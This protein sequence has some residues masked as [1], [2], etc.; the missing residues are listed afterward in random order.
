MDKYNY[1]GITAT[2][3]R[4]LSLGSIF[5]AAQNPTV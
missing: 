2:S 5:K 3:S 4:E 1:N